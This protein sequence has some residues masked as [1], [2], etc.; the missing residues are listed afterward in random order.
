MQVR[1]HATHCSPR[2]DAGCRRQRMPGM[3]TAAGCSLAVDIASTVQVLQPRADLLRRQHRESCRRAHAGAST[4]ATAATGIRSTSARRLAVNFLAASHRERSACIRDLPC[5]LEC[6]ACWPPSSARAERDRQAV[7]W[8]GHT[9]TLS[10]A[11]AAPRAAT[12]RSALLPQLPRR[13]HTHTLCSSN[14]TPKA[15]RPAHP[16]GMTHACPSDKRQSCCCRLKLALSSRPHLLMML[17][18]IP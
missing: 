5:L 16:I 3:N 12:A 1:M 7:P 15:A 4:A 9:G 11:L 8:V 18:A 13:T 6:A 17:P 14:H 2:Q 10:H